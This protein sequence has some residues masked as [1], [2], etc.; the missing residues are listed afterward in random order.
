MEGEETVIVFT[1]ILLL[2]KVIKSLLLQVIGTEC[3]IVWR[4]VVILEIGLFLS[5]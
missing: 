5:F 1:E 4:F 3:L 2:K